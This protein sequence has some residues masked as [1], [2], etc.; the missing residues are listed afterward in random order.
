[1]SVA[2]TIEIISG[3]S[4][5]L[6]DAVRQGIAKASETVNG[7]S[8]AWVKDTEVAVSDNRVTEWRVRL[9]ITFVVK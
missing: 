2:K 4:T 6:E 1:M 3:S 9:K 7:I 5:S 8:G